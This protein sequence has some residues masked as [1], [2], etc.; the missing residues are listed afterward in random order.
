MP[1]WLRVILVIGG[2]LLLIV[3]GAAGAGWWW[4]S[5]HGRQ[6]LKQGVEQG[7]VAMKEGEA[8]A[9][10]SDQA[11]CVDAAFLRRKDCASFGCQLDRSL[12]M[13]ACLHKARETPGFCDGIPATTEIIA[14]VKWRIERCA[15]RGNAGDQACTQ[16][17]GA[18]QQFCDHPIR[19]NS[20]P[21][22]PESAAP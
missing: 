5:H 1:V 16:L 12:F 6:A 7:K 13:A 15:A 8:F 10:E 19:D 21:A 4:W 2:L 22:P 14:S 20:A 3:L 17:Y 9:A 11:G 18:V